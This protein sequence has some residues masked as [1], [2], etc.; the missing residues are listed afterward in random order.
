MKKHVDHIYS[1]F[2]GD[3]RGIPVLSIVCVLNDNYEGGEFKFIEYEK[4]F[5]LK[6]NSALVFPAIY[7]HQVCPIKKGKRFSLISFLIHK[8]F[9]ELKKN[10]DYKI[11]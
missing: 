10:N 5:K 3:K 6:K 7:S 2:T 1:L 9:G 8:Q 11:K 4:E